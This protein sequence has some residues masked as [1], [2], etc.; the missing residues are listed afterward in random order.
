LEVI[1]VYS[2]SPIKT[3]GLHQFSNL[4]LVRLE[5]SPDQ[6]CESESLIKA[7][8]EADLKYQVAVQQMPTPSRI[9]LQF[10]VDYNRVDRFMDLM[11][12][13]FG[14]KQALSPQTLGPV[15][16]VHFSGPHFG[17]RYGVAAAAFA[18]VEEAGL[19]V[20]LSGFSASSVYMVLPVGSVEKLRPYWTKHFELPFKS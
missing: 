17:D 1:A 2:E 16:L 4:A 19:A 20:V 6:T 5:Y 9:V 8:N 7:L 12:D 3:Y 11:A 18:A 13:Q 14:R 10:V 15:E